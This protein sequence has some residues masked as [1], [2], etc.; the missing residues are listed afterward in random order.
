[1]RV[2][3]EVIVGFP[4]FAHYGSRFQ[5]FFM[6]RTPLTP[7][8]PYEWFEKPN[9]HFLSISDLRDYCRMQDI[10]IKKSAFIGN[11]GFY[12]LLPSSF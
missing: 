9:L 10:W 11:N 6:G 12:G 3:K 4:N 8:L 7:S 2:G 5:I 1:L